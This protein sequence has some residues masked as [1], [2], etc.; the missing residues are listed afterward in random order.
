MDFEAFYA[1]NYA[2]VAAYLRRRI[3]NSAAAEDLA[4]DVFEYCY[5]HFAQFDSQ[6]AS[7]KTWLY[8]VVNSRLKN[9][10]RDRHE[11]EDFDDYEAILQDESLLEQSVFLTQFRSA[12]A[13]ALKTLPEKQYKVFVQKHFAQQSHSEIAAELGISEA[14][15]RVLLS[16]ALDSLRIILEE[17]KDW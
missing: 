4:Q 5:R 12:L 6:K 14:N 3:G 2:R 17:Y 15:S 11:T 16:R 9:Y 1:G 8:L 10:Y 7:V 13:K